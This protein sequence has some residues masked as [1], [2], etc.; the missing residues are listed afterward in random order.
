MA[1]LHG[2]AL[3]TAV[4]LWAVAAFGAAFAL[5]ILAIVLP[6]RF[7]EKRLEKAYI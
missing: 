2:Q 5:S 1:D 7:G 6:L 4:W 3:S